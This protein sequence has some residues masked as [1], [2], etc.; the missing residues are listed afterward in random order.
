MTVARSEV[1]RKTYK[2]LVDYGRIINN[3]LPLNDYELP[4]SRIAIEIEV[5]TVCFDRVIELK[6]LPRELL[7]VSLR[8]AHLEEF[9]AFG[10]RYKDIPLNFPVVISINGWIF[11]LGFCGAPDAWSDTG[12]NQVIMNRPEDNSYSFHKYVH[13]LAVK[14]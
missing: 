2:I 3:L 4:G 9:L 12:W 10:T 7:E 8:L 6:D 1:Q 13:F 14:I 11:T 5:E